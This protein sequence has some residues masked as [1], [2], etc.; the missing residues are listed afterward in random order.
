MALEGVQGREGVS[1][2]IEKDGK[3]FSRV[4]LEELCAILRDLKCGKQRLLAALNGR[5][6]VAW[7]D[8]LC[9]AGNADRHYEKIRSALD[10]SWSLVVE[11]V[12][13]PFYGSQWNE[14]VDKIRIDA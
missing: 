10:D 9:T 3:E 1:V 8:P 12:D 7:I 4:E 6:R 14:V 5:V 2:R 11:D 13:S